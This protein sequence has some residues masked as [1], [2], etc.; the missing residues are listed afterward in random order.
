MR[1]GTIEGLLVDGEVTSE[2]T[3]NSARDAGPISELLILYPPG[4]ASI[5]CLLFCGHFYTEDIR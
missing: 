3:L 4:A 2:Q 5:I 1:Q